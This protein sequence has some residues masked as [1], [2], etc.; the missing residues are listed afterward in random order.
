MSASP[1]RMSMHFWTPTSACSATPY[2]LR[3]GRPLCGGGQCSRTAEL[4]HITRHIHG[5]ASLYRS[6]RWPITSHGATNSR[7]AGVLMLSQCVL[8]CLPEICETRWH[9]AVK[10]A[11]VPYRHVKTGKRMYFGV[12]LTTGPVA[13]IDNLFRQMLPAL[14]VAR[15]D[16]S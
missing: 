13:Q 11:V 3:C 4:M 10:S 12:H 5:S 1:I 2:T 9:C 15:P 8:G 6:K 14:N 16:M 7:K